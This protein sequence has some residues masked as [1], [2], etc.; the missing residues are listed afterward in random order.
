VATTEFLQPLADQLPR[1]VTW[2]RSL[3]WPAA[4]ALLALGLLGLFL[5]AR[6][7][8]AVAGVGGFA[9]GALAG[10]TFA[11]PA[12]RAASL[13]TAGSA[14]ACGLAVAALS[15]AVP[16]AFPFTL[17]AVIGAPLGARLP[18]NVPALGPA[19]GAIAVGGILV[20]ASKLVAASAAGLLGG[21]MVV[22]GVLAI[23][24]DVAFLEPLAAHPVVAIGL[25]LVIGVAGA[26]GQVGGAWEA[27]APRSRRPTLEQP[28][29]VD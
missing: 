23:S 25:A 2:L 6:R 26:A 17:G 4:A 14:L 29:A 19:L 15:F 3:P 10:L 13:G 1:G 9:A 20:L 18:V 28:K 21:A 22:A 16:W 5:G 7:R 11:A 24:A 12:L 27:S 8:R